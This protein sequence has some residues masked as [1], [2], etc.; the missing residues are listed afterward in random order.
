L[1]SDQAVTPCWF[2]AVSAFEVVAGC[3]TRK[4]NLVAKAQGPIGRAY[5][6]RL[7]PGRQAPA[8]NVGVNV[9]VILKR[10]RQDDA[11]HLSAVVGVVVAV[12]YQV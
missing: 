1:A 2:A 10:H 11:G 7:H 9:S 3:P 12:G 8:H 6:L 5:L 4:L